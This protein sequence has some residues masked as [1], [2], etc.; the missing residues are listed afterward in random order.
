VSA[1][2]KPS[3]HP[4]VSPYLLVAGAERTIDFLVHVLGGKLLFQMPGP[5]GRVMHAEVRLDD[6]VIMLADNPPGRPPAPSNVHIYVPD[7]DA[8]YHAAIAWGAVP[9]Q[10]PVKKADP[11]K[12]GGVRDPGGT[13]WWLATKME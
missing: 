13:T 1:P 3:D 10:E 2:Y 7:V 8:A 5:D 12:R 4:S 9:V 6:S 11:D